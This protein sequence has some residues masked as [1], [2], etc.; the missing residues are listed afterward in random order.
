M[1]NRY[2]LIGPHWLFWLG[3]ILLSLSLFSFLFPDVLSSST[4]RERLGFAAVSL[5]VMLVGGLSY[6]LRARWQERPA[7]RERVNPGPHR[8]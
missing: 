4:P 6:W 8:I 2:T 5:V 1:Y 3:L 7:Y